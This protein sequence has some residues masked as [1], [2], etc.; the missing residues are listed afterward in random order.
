M[1]CYSNNPFDGLDLEGRLV[2]NKK[3]KPHKT[4]QKTHNK[5]TKQQKPPPTTKQ[6]QKNLKQIEGTAMLMAIL[7]LFKN[8][9]KK[10]FFKMQNA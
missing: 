10:F 8:S 9:M 7:Y 1:S 2:K 3:Q 6:K 4:H 5:Q